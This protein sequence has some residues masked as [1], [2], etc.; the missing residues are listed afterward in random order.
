ML[1]SIVEFVSMDKQ[2]S[3]YSLPIPKLSGMFIS[4]TNHHKLKS[5]L[6]SIIQDTFAKQEYIPIDCPILEPTELYERKSGGE[7][8]KRLYSFTEPNG[9]K[10]S[11]RP[12][13]T[14]SIIRI[15]IEDN[16][17][18]SHTPISRFQYCGP[19]FRNH[20]TNLASSTKQ[21]TQLGAELIGNNSI[22][23]DAEILS[24]SLESISKT[25]VKNGNISIGNVGPIREFLGNSGFTE[26]LTDFTLDNIYKIRAN[27]SID[28]LAQKALDLGLLSLEI[29]EN[30]SPNIVDIQRILDELETSSDSYNFG[31]RTSHEIIDR[32]KQK[33][34]ISLTRSDYIKTLTILYNFFKEFSK[35]TVGAKKSDPSYPE[36]LSKS[37]SYISQVVDEV[38]IP[39]NLKAKFVIDFERNRGLTYYT[40]IVFDLETEINS[41]TK[42]FGGGGR[43]DKLFTAL[44]HHTDIPAIGF[45]INIDE[46]I[47]LD[48]GEI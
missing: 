25:S 45:A 26:A 8:S 37:I 3:K 32:L 40:G 20:E 1:R 46:I 11:L 4:D 36:E 18:Q 27:H 13:F 9:R 41:Q 6:T 47:S 31:R 33:Q 35:T 34:T 12:E 24:L 23:S 43:Y 21:F 7:I 15:L 42:T 14:S 2:I 28:S 22:K 16:L 17:S 38:I 48:Q 5:Q 30:K 44:G 19:V 29:P 39:K 10:V